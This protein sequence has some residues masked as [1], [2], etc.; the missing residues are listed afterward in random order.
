MVIPLPFPSTNCVAFF[1]IF[2]QVVVCEG[3]DCF[4][5]GVLV[6]FPRFFPLHQSPT[7]LSQPTESITF[8]TRSSEIFTQSINFDIDGPTAVKF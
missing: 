2:G 7:S 1:C 6:D 4:T 8:E 5:G 3:A